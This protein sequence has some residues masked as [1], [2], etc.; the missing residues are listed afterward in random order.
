V[1]NN[2]VNIAEPVYGSAGS[3]NELIGCEWIR[4]RPAQFA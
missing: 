3:V 1:T 2:L 4:R